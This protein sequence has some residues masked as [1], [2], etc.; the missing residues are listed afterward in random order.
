MSFDRAFHAAATYASP[1]DLEGFRRHISPEWIEQALEAT[2]VATVRRRRLP[3]EQVIWVVLGMALYRGQA[4]EDVVTKLDLALPGAGTIARSSVTQARERVGKEPLKWLF[5]RCSSKWAS[6]S[7]DAHRWRGLGLYGI[8]G[9]S[10]RVPNT[11]E[12]RRKF[13]GHSSRGSESGVSVR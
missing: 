11:E 2:D 6:E 9:S 12:N 8:D 1:P 7:S 5:N 3:S 10:I 13:G 4:I